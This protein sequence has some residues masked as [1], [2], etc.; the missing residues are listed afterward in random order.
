MEVGSLL[1]ILWALGTTPRCLWTIYSL[2]FAYGELR[3]KVTV[4]PTWP[5]SGAARRVPSC[6]YGHGHWLKSA[7]SPKPCWGSQLRAWKE[8]AAYVVCVGASRWEVAHAEMAGDSQ[9]CSSKLCLGLGA[10]LETRR[11]TS[12]RLLGSTWDLL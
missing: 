4:S 3:K 1:C 11:G 5:G 8:N 2:S 10:V 12:V 9:G 6:R 7:L